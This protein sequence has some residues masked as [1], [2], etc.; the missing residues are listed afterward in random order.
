MDYLDRIRNSPL[1]V[2]EMKDGPMKEAH[3]AVAIEDVEQP[4]AAVV[5]KPR[6]KKSESC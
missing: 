3:I 2:K 4:L 1:W 5:S 6:H